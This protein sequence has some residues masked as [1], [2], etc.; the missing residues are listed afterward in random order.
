MAGSL[1]LSGSQGANVNVAARCTLGGL[2]QVVSN[3]GLLH[4]RSELRLVRGAR[5]AVSFG[6]AFPA[7]ATIPRRRTVTSITTTVAEY[8]S[9]NGT[10]DD[11]LATYAGDAC[12]IVGTPQTVYGSSTLTGESILAEGLSEVTCFLLSQ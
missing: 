5:L 12:V 10:F 11:V 8:G 3:R 7:A 6:N 2:L 9:L 4:V 1:D